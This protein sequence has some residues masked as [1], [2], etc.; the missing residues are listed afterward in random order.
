MNS[1]GGIVGSRQPIQA[2]DTMYKLAHPWGALV[3]LDTRLFL[4]RLGARDRLGEGSLLEECLPPRFPLLRRQV[5]P[6]VSRQGSASEVVRADDRAEHLERGEEGPVTSAFERKRVLNKEQP[7]L[8]RIRRRPKP[9]FLV[10]APS[11][12]QQRILH[13]QWERHEEYQDG[14]VQS[15]SATSSA[16]KPNRQ[17]SLAIA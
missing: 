4:H 8:R 17:L 13:W 6:S 12:S 10:A 15:R 11:G 5:L 7:S 14:V 2:D 16:C 3:W 1:F 9:S